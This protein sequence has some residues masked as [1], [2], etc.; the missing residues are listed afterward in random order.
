MG[1]HVACEERGR[2][3]LA[4]L[5]AG[6]EMVRVVVMRKAPAGLPPWG[7]HHVAKLPCR[8]TVSNRPQAFLPRAVWERGREK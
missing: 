1:E 2:D 3:L 5:H 6:D 4:L 8:A 7:T